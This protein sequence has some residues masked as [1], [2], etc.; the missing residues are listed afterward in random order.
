MYSRSNFNNN[1]KKIDIYR[2][3]IDRYIKLLK[4]V[5]SAKQIPQFNNKIRKHENEDI[6]KKKDLNYINVR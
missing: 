2:N 3:Q 1:D 6:N 5:R 4:N